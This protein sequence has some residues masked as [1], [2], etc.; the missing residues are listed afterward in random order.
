MDLKDCKY[1]GRGSFK[2]DE[3]DTS[4]HMDK[5]ER[6]KYEQL[7]AA[8]TARIAELQN[9]L[10]AE[11]KEGV[12]II[13]QAMDAGGKDSTIRHVL[14]G[15][16]PQGCKVISFKQP[17]KEEL[18][19]SFMWRAF[20]A[21]PERGYLGVFNRSYY[22]DV[23]VVR[24]HN[25]QK[26][27]ALPKRCVDMPADEFFGKRLTHINNFEEYLWDSGVRIIKI[28]LHVSKDEQ[29]KRFLSRIDD[30]AKN[31]KFSEAD[32]SERKLWDKY[33]GVY[34][35]TIAKTGSKHCPWYV[36]PADQKW[37]A[38][39]L[40]SELIK[41]VLEDINPQFPQ[42]PAEQVEKLAVYREQLLA[43]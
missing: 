29:K 2:I 41:D 7:M 31:W 13:I 22:E 4:A 3:Y 23:L 33:Q 42:M 17:S 12:V 11:A 24:V 1:D 37:Y 6:P 9:R 39:Y 28:F 18:A 19:H 36:I 10:Y 38:R 5:K 25:M 43:D 20:R 14:S 40:V 30:E 27:Y 16:N 35:E 15:V 32:V 34:E 26:D 21:M 8:N